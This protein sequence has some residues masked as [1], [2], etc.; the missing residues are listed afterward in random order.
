MESDLKKYFRR[1]L[2]DAQLIEH[3][4]KIL[5][6]QRVISFFFRNN[7]PVLAKIFGSDKWGDHTYCVH[8]ERLF[9]RFKRDQFNLLEIGVGG[10][11]S[12]IHGG[13]SL[14]MWKAYF[15]KAQ[16]F[17]IDIHDKSVQEEKRI[18]IHQGDQSDRLFLEE[19][20]KKLGSARII[21]DDGSHVGEDIVISFETLFPYLE[22]GGVYVVEDVET[23]YRGIRQDHRGGLDA[24]FNAVNYF[25]GLIHGLNYR[26]FGNSEFQPSYLD[27]KILSL[28][29]IHNMIFVFKGDN[30]STR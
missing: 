8:Y 24:P 12:E 4:S 15:P 5:V 9:S 10:D 3:R 13:N 26:E 17:G 16:I 18:S 20:G 28:Q 14:R 1:Y 2:N 19:I 21:I 7:L 6:L 11:S 23:A 22:N 30:S 27:E 29:F 25:K